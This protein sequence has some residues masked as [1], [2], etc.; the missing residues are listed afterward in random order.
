MTNNL[1]HDRKTC[2]VE[3]L[4]CTQLKPHTKQFAWVELYKHKDYFG[5]IWVISELEFCLI[6]KFHTLIYLKYAK[7]LP[8]RMCMNRVSCVYVKTHQPNT[9]YLSRRNAPW[10]FFLIISLSV[11]HIYTQ[12]LSENTQNY[13]KT[14]TLQLRGPGYTYEGTDQIQA[15]PTPL[16]KFWIR[17]NKSS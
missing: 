2:H 4:N 8:I 5:P 15:F 10:E 1:R 17:D 9:G 11:T 3:S 7:M 6:I 14:S 16:I 13:H 12:K